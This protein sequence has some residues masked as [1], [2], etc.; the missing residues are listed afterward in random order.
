MIKILIV[1]RHMHVGGIQKSLIEL[2]KVLSQDERYDISLFCCLKRGALLTNI[3]SNIKILDENPYAAVTEISASDC[4]KMGIKYA[5][6]RIFASG[7]TK[8]FTKRIPVKI[9]SHLVGKIGDSY[10]V[11]VSYA[12][13]A[14]DHVFCALTNEFV[15]NCTEAEKKIGFVHSDFANYGGNT[16]LNRAIYLQFDNIAAVTESLKQSF[17]KIMPQIVLNR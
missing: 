15:L 2:L 13:P 11:V 1:T 12:Q 8:L 7:F 6:L 10:D 3:P 9:F 17:V 16:T 4:K 14:E 5:L